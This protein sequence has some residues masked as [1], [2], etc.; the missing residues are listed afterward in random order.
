MTDVLHYSHPLCFLKQGYLDG[1]ELTNSARLDGHQV[2]E[3]S[4]L[5]LPSMEIASKY[6]HVLKFGCC[7]W[8]EY[9]THASCTSVAST[10]LAG[11]Q[12]EKFDLTKS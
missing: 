7:C 10:L 4:Y 3:S 5:C 1:L 12:P 8:F 6:H 9:K 2:K 11:L